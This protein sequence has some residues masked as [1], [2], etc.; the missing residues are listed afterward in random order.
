MLVLGGGVAGEVFA[1]F[2]KKKHPEEEVVVIEKSPKTLQ[3]VLVSGNGRCNFFNQA[4]LDENFQKDP[5]FKKASPILQG[6]V[7]QKAFDA[8][9]SYFNIPYY[10]IDNLYYPFANKSE[11]VKNAID[12]K[13]I[14]SGVLFKTGEFQGIEKKENKLSVLVNKERMDADLYVFALGGQCLN[15]PPFDWSRLAPLGLQYKEFEPALAPL[16]VK[17]NTKPLDGTRIKGIV[18]LLEKGKPIYQ[19]EGEILFKKDGLS[20]ICIFNASIRINQHHFSDYTI[21]LNLTQHDGSF[22]PKINRNNI[23]NFYP[24]VLSDYLLALTQSKDLTTLCQGLSF[25]VKGVYP[26]KAAEVS[27]GGIDLNEV[28][29]NTMLLKKYPNVSILGETLDAPVPCGGYNIG[30]CIIE[31]YRLANRKGK[32]T[33]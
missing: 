1:C 8:F 16:F 4:Y 32:G 5:L 20:G 2:E 27:K 21:Q 19:E 13:A 10:R 7:G 29:T 11:V 23:F 24:R 15:Y 17:E 9:T 22:L 12:S 6:G 28:D 31:A 3:R 18:T 14:Q 25:H 26:F 33:L 30:L